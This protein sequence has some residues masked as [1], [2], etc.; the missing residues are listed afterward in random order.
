MKDYTTSHL[1]HVL[2]STFDL[3]VLNLCY[4]LCC[5][6]I[7]TIGSATAALYRV[8]HAMYKEEGA[9]VRDFFRSFKANLRLGIPAWLLWLAAAAIACADFAIIGLFWDISGKYIL[10]GLLALVILVL[11][12]TGSCL[13][14]ILS[15]CTSLKDAFSHA[16]FLSIRHL[17]RVLPACVIHLL[18]ILIFLFWSYG[19]LLLLGFLLLIWFSL[20]A[21]INAILL[22]PILAQA[23]TQA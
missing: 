4:I 14:S 13:F 1:Y 9:P 17:P 2:C 20:S 12:L 21:Y 23:E 8:V 16:F 22:R 15:W 19:F 11:L 18:P 10:L 6:P 7:I 5:L 3:V